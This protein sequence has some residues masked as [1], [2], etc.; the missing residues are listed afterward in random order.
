MHMYSPPSQRRLLQ[1]GH[2]RRPEK[3]DRGEQHGVKQHRPRADFLEDLLLLLLG[4]GDA[5]NRR[6][7]QLLAR[8]EVLHQDEG[9]EGEDDPAGGPRELDRRRRLDWHVRMS[10]GDRE[11]GAHFEQRRKYGDEGSGLIPTCRV[12]CTPLLC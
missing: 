8:L 10:S 9:G 6:A 4:R 5:C 12:E 11:M 7:L 3:D 1:T 2:D